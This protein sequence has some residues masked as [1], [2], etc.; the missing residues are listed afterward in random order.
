[1]NH[2]KTFS[3]GEIMAV[4]A[5]R[6]LRDGERVLAGTGIP[7]V[8]ATLAKYT[9]APNLNILIEAGYGKAMPIH[10]FVGTA[11][12]RALYRAT[13]FTTALDM[14]GMVLHRGKVETGFLTGIEVDVYGNLNLTVT[15]SWEIP[16]KRVS[17]G[18][19][20]N[21]IASMSDR[22]LIIMKHERRRFPGKVSHNT[23]PGHID[24]PDGRGKAGL[25]GKGPELVFSDLAVLGFDD[26]NKRMKLVSLHPGVTIEEVKENTQFDLIIP[27]HIPTTETPTQ[28]EQDL[29]RN[30]IDTSGFYTGWQEPTLAWWGKE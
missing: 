12:N 26:D 20:A 16:E 29:I 10:P 17:G 4:A 18:G 5:A 28:K 21:D 8:A 11:D 1:V 30:T 2:A 9:H 22:I 19:G 14:N 13:I 23:A 3:Q 24:G 25:R 6:A 15:P 27:P 7:M